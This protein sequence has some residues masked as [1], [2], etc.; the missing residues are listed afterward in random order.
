MENETIVNIS[1]P[2]GFGAIGVVRISGSNSLYI[3]KKLI[4]KEI[5]IKPRFAYHFFLY[6]NNGNSL[7]DSITIFYKS[8]NS[9]T[10]EDVVEI[11]TFSSPVL[12]DRIITTIIE[13]GGRLSKPGEF[14]ERA[15][16]NG[17]ID[18]I[19]AQAI[20]KIVFS[21]D[22]YEL[23]SSINTLEGKLTKKV[24]E[25][26]EDLNTLRIKIE[27]SISFPDDVE[28]VRGYEIQEIV[29]KNL[30]EINT[31]LSKYEDEKPF[32]EG[33]KLTIFGKANVGKSSLFNILMEEERVI[34]SE[35]PGTTR[36]VIREKIYI[37][38]VPVEIIDTAGVIRKIKNSLDKIAQER[39]E[40]AL[41]SSSIILLLF[42]Q[43]VPLDEDDFYAI[44]KVKDKNF[45]PI[46]NKN[47]LPFAFKKED[48]EKVIGKNLLSISCLTKEGI[49]NLKTKITENYQNKPELNE[50]FYITLREKNLLLQAKNLL[51]EILD[52][53]LTLDEI[54]I[55]L[56]DSIKN[57][58]LIIGEEFDE[59]TINEIF[60]SFC[61]GK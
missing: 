46:L 22:L 7:G 34:V 27:G 52:N 24:K 17:K 35:I 50:I 43:S 57:L 28:E 3:L 32:I 31:I 29:T 9:Y 60:S 4:K 41:S 56:Q 55:N 6:D 12:I 58:K 8:P 61:I 25:V 15:F 5:E 48:L 53:K 1:T 59:N 26:V 44:E 33:I 18:L 54:S 39:S 14:T 19:S 16:L 37:E 20:N 21:S 10:G 38:G 45:I 42:D 49:D 36:D 30:K 11:Q 23:Q 47:D 2:K 40:K 51:K 13:Y